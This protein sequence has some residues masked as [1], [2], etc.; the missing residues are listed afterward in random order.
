MFLLLLC[1]LHTLLLLTLTAYNRWP[2]FQVTLRDGW[3]AH[4]SE[5]EVQVLARDLSDRQPVGYK[6]QISVLA[7]EKRFDWIMSILRSSEGGPLGKVTDSIVKKECQCR[8]AVH[9]HM[10]IWGEPPPQ[11]QLPRTQ[12]HIVRT[13]GGHHGGEIYK[14]L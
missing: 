1:V 12:V 5:L 11:A 7:A 2:Q 6:P 4:A 8:G 9:W 14:V 10:L 13:H 3:G